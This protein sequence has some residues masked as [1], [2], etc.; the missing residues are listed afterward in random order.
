MLGILPLAGRLCSMFLGTWE[1]GPEL[2]RSANK[3][4][5]RL[6]F[7]DSGSSCLAILPRGAPI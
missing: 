3:E 2:P 1:L 7:P 4:A 6:L 5:V